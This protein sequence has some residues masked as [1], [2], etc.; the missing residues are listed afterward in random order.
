[1]EYSDCKK[2]V[3]VL[4][5][6]SFGHSTLSI[7]QS[8]GVSGTTCLT[9]KIGKYPA[10]LVGKVIQIESLA[11]E[12]RNAHYDLVIPMSLDWPSIPGTEIINEKKIP[13]FGP[14]PGGLL[15]ERDRNF[16]SELCRQFGISVP[17]SKVASNRIEAERILAERNN[18]TVI[19]NPLC[20]PNSPIQAIVCESNAETR[21]WFE[22]ID[23]SEGVFLQEYMGRHEVGHVAF[24]SH[25]EIYPVATNQEY[26][27][28]FSGN[29]GSIA[30]APLGGIVEKD[31]EDKYGLVADLLTPLLPWLR[32]VNYHGPIQVTAARKNN[33]WHVLEYNAR[34]GVTSGP[35]IMRMLRNPYEAMIQIATN[36][37]FSVE[38]LEGINFGCSISLA[39]H[40]FPY[41]E[42]GSPNV[43][44]TIEGD[45]DC[46]LWWNQVALSNSKNHHVTLGQ[47]IL[48]INTVSYDL[49][50]AL[51]SA[52][53]NI[54]KIKCGGSYY[55]TDIG[56]C[57][58]PPGQ[59]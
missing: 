15:I 10:E 39:G 32:E 47:R 26:K 46:D 34:I 9:K 50:G 1:M 35:L 45:V 22:K 20:A 16:A 29:M 37:K 53:S 33:K 5:A 23:Y 30:G 38:F 54:R 17:E 57:L 36:Q 43:P 19:K 6:G 31:T 44:I 48:D 59:S 27:R 24:V 4:G 55:R 11:D 7:L 13:V 51:D 14:P 2:K 42:V 12:L 56:D 18:L 41:P 49:T 8:A 3:S 28:C 52:Y 58:W 21:A 40:G 25:G